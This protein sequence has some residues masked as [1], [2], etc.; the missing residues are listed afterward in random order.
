MDTRPEDLLITPVVDRQGA[1][2]Y[3]ASPWSRR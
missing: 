2:R 3:V 1:I